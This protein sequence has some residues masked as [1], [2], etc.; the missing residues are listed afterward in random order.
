ML[1]GLSNALGT[2]I[3]VLTKVLKLFL[4]FLMNVYLDD[5]LIYNISNEEHLTHLWQVI[6]VHIRKK[7]LSYEVVF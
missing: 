6:V 4:N 1:F 5:I 7:I 2:F 3:Q